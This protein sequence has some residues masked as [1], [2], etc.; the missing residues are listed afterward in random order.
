MRVSDKILTQGMAS[1]LQNNLENVVKAQRIVSSGKILQKPSDDP[2]GISRSLNYNSVLSSLEQYQENITDAN[3]WLNITESALT[4]V[5]DAVTNA[6]TEALKSI[7]ATTSAESRKASAMV[8]SDL[9]D[10]IL[11]A[12]NTKV[13]GRYIFGGTKTKTQPF[14]DDGTYNGDTNNIERIVAPGGMSISIN[15]N[16]EE[17]FKTGEDIFDTFQDLI[18]GLNNNDTQAISDQLDR[19]NTSLNQVLQY[20][21]EVGSKM[22]EMQAVQ[23]QL[24]DMET[25]VTNLLSDI[26]DADITKAVMDLTTAQNIYQASLAAATMLF[27]TTLVDF[28]K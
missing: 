11:K 25:N 13:Q 23:T 17:V 2:T 5:N 10:V 12:A 6:K 21:G 26:E 27:Q 8:V 20:R 22:N 16:G 19:L 9:R 7:N 1:D 24:T 28:L 4:Q 14:E 18:D 15:L 3:S